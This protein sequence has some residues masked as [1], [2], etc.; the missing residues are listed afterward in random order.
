M[1]YFRRYNK[2]KKRY[3]KYKKRYRKSY[4]RGTYRSRKYGRSYRSRKFSRRSGFGRRKKF[5]LSIFRLRRVKKYGSRRITERALFHYVSS[6]ALMVKF[7]GAIPAFDNPVW[8]TAKYERKKFY[9]FVGK[10]LRMRYAQQLDWVASFQ[11]QFPCTFYRLSEADQG[12]VIARCNSCILTANA[13]YADRAR[14]GS[15]Y[16]LKMARRARK[17]ARYEAIL[18]ALLNPH[19]VLPQTTPMMPTH[20]TP[21]GTQGTNLT[22]AMMDI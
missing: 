18:S 15:K 22:Q 10:F 7:S 1:A 8:G 14:P 17:Q 2:Y 3:R 4:G 12:V 21:Q 20:H 19:G 13:V 6:Y 11:K 5:S 16:E 9:R